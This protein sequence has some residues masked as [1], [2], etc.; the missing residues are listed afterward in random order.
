MVFKFLVTCLVL[1]ISEWASF[2]MVVADSLDHLE[3]ENQ[4]LLI[5]L[6]NQKDRNCCLVAPH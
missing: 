2:A 1:C 4:S 3:Y 6:G 5:Y